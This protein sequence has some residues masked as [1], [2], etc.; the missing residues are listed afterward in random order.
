MDYKSNSNLF[1]PEFVKRLTESTVHQEVASH[2][3]FLDINYLESS[4]NERLQDLK[5]AVRA[6]KLFDIEPNSFIFPF[7]KFDDV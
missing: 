3:F 4:S 1:I 2:G 5:K 7:N 6:L